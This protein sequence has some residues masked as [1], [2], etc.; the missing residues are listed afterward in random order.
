MKTKE[1][2]KD[3]TICGN[4]VRSSQTN[5]NEENTQKRR[6]KKAKQHRGMDPRTK[7]VPP[8]CG[9]TPKNFM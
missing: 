6:H 2:S 4:F 1:A 8:A 3:I 5:S 7:R 9:V